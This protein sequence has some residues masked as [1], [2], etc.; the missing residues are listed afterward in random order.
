MELGVL[1]LTVQRTREKQQQNTTH[2]GCFFHE[3]RKSQLGKLRKEV[4]GCFHLHGDKKQSQWLL[5]YQL[6][7]KTIGKRAMK[8]LKCKLSKGK[9]LKK[10]PQQRQD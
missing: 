6:S 7:S 2:F 1:Y 4:L 8:V 9:Q 5:N 10:A 3:P